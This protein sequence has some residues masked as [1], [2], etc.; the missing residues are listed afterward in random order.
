M[1]SYIASYI[2]FKY[3]ILILMK[4]KNFFGRIDLYFLG[5]RE[6]LNYFQGFGEFKQMLLG[7]RGN[8]LQ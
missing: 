2:V 3:V 7:R 5:F 1:H 6:K 4:D 8:Y